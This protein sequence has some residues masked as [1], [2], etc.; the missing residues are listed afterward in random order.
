MTILAS[1]II[2]QVKTRLNDTNNNNRRWPDAVLLTNLNLAQKMVA[3]GVPESSMFNGFFELSAGFEQ[4]LP[5]AAKGLYT[6]D[7]NAGTDGNTK[8]NYITRIQSQQ[9][10]EID[11]DWRGLTETDEV[12]HYYF[13]SDNPSIFGVY[14]PNT[15][16][17]QVHIIYPILPTDCATT[18]SEISLRDEDEESLVQATIFHTLADRTEYQDMRIIRNEALEYLKLNVNV[19][20]S[21]EEPAK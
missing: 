3:N 4:T 1:V 11:P 9:L 7:Y 5:D 10:D 19:Q 16:D 18:S 15:G 14:P 12:Q 2:E 6:I 21:A 13:E 20:A 17:Q 8:G